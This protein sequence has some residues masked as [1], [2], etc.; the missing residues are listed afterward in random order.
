MSV[1]KMLLTVTANIGLGAYT[2]GTG[3]LN[4][5]EQV[6]SYIVPFCA[7]VS[8]LHNITTTLVVM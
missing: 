2:L 3:L 5:C 8:A 7:T 4:S 1:S 6:I